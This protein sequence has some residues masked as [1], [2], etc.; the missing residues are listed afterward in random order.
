[1][2][3]QIEAT[4]EQLFPSGRHMLLHM[5]PQLFSKVSL[6]DAEKGLGVRRHPSTGV[7]AELTMCPIIQAAQVHWCE[8][9]TEWLP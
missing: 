7:V 6:A 4:K 5:C 9:A 2:N 1:M 8:D 3:H